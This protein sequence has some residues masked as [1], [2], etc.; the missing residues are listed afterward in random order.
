MSAGYYTE[1]VRD[2]LGAFDS[3][4]IFMFEDLQRDPAAVVRSIFELIGVN[5]TGFVPWNIN[6]TYNA[7]G[8]PKSGFSRSVY[9]LLFHDITMK[10]YFKHILPLRWRLW[11]K[12]EVSAK[13]M[14]KV[15][16]PADVRE[17]LSKTYRE[18]MESL[19]DLLSDPAQK[20]VV[21]KWRL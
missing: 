17:F 11:I 5:D 12:A 10:S 8:S 16:I 21:D 6:T 15:E 18:S 9:N 20:A 2:Y 13:I 3:V 7:S 4:R 1:P 19:R 14:K